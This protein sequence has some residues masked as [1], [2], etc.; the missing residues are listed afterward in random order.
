MTPPGRE[1]AQRR[2]A[3]E[4]ARAEYADEPLPDRLWRM[5]QQWLG[6]LTDVVPGGPPVGAVL[7]ALLLILVVVVAVWVTV[8][9]SRRS[10]RTR[11]DDSGDLFGGRAMT[12]AEH[13][14]AAERLAAEGRW[15]EAVQERLRA[16]ARDLQDR[17]L[18]DNLPGRTADELAA[19]AGRSLPA[20]ADELTAAARAFDD[21]AY[22]GVPGTPDS[23]AMLRELD[24]RLRVARPVVAL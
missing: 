15:A 2:A 24:E 6:D 8:W 22:G 23:Y 14:M 9:L 11:A 7:A 19:E 1:E 5:F 17:A 10:A 12:A 16:I 4:L 18:V 13:R 21:V 3:E 20:F